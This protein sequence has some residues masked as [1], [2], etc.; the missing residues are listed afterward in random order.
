MNQNNYLIESKK[1]TPITSPLKDNNITNTNTVIIENNNNNN[2]NV[3]KI[4]RLL[5]H[6]TKFPPFDLSFLN[7]LKPKKKLSEFGYIQILKSKKI[8]IFFQ[9]DSTGVQI[10][11]NGFT[12]SLCGNNPSP[13]NC[14]ISQIP[15]SWNNKLSFCY[16]VINCLKSFTP[17]VCINGGN[18]ICKLMSNNP[19]PD[20]VY[21]TLNY[22]F[23]YYMNRKYL[24]IKDISN[25]KIYYH[26]LCPDNNGNYIV[27]KRT[28]T[29]EFCSCKMNERYEN[30][31]DYDE[32]EI[33]KYANPI[34]IE[35]NGY[36]MDGFRNYQLC[37]KI[38]EKYGKNRSDTIT[39]NLN[40]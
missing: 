31:D 17:Q 24:K 3:I 25:N 20:F 5:P 15:N 39:V 23:F 30:N 38:K 19:V 2:R 1:S 32:I 26:S 11:D 29:N 10:Q 27:D 14:S 37:L 4:D 21:T 16:K 36:I 8:R 6:Y 22:R 12:V 13:I 28:C 7:I 33:S 34:P 18:Y 35:F 40:H 9:E